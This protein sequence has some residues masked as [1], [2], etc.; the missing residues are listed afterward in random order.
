MYRHVVRPHGYHR[1]GVR[2]ERWVDSDGEPLTDPD[3]LDRLA[4]LRIP[5]AWTS[6]WA[7]P[8]AASRVQATGVDLR[9]RTQYRYSDEA[10]AVAER[11]KFSRLLEFAAALP[12]IRETVRGHLGHGAASAS[13][14]ERSTAAVV[15]LLD[16]GLFRVGNERYARDNDTYGLTTLRREHVEVGGPMLTFSFVGKEHIPHRIAVE[17]GAAAAVVGTL[18]RQEPHPEGRLFALADPP[19]WRLVDSATVNSYLHAHAG[20]A[21]TAKVFRTWGATVAA[22]TIVAGAR[23]TDAPR[24]RRSTVLYAYDGAAR[25]LGDTPAVAR[26]SYVH[27]AAEEIGSSPA[28]RAAVAAAIEEARDDDFAVVYQDGGVQAAVLD[29]LRRSGTVTA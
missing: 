29:G 8:D 27:P 14:V 5:P 13:A 26:A 21:V 6:V 3:E 11:D 7:A 15:R 16:R 12:A 18:L 28:V 23:L 10:R 17:D 2:P 9:G 19:I 1:L 24:A 4:R 25:L 20:C 22:C